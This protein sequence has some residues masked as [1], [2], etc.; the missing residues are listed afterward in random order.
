MDYEDIS[1]KIW[2]PQLENWPSYG[3]SDLHHHDHHVNHHH[4]HNHHH[5]HKYHP[6]SN[7][8]I[9]YHV[10]SG[11]PSLK[12]VRVM[13]FLIFIIMFIIIIIIMMIIIII[14]IIIVSI[15]I[16]VLFRSYTIPSLKIGR[17]MA[18]LIFIIMFIIIISIIIIIILHPQVLSKSI[19]MQNFRT[20][21]HKL[22][23]LQLFLSS[24]P[25]WCR[26]TDIS[27]FY[28]FRYVVSLKYD[29]IYE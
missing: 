25:K 13:D 24:V 10:K 9:Y 5:Y 8:Q 22:A 16:Q 11:P 3:H 19:T 15:S 7:M 2:I 29:A 14:I 1:H 20:Q 28:L 17:V 18:I 6:L 21:A 26:K 12:I 4:Q 27:P 23:E